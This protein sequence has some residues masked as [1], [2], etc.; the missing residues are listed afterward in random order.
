MAMA[1]PAV[2]SAEALEGIAARPGTELLLADTPEA[3][4]A[5][6]HRLAADVTQ[7]KR[8]GEAAR[9]RVVADYSWEGRL[10]SFD[11]LLAP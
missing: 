10:A 11:R 8:I 3:F 5:A 7:G 1:R 2:V 4:A 9:R 6:A